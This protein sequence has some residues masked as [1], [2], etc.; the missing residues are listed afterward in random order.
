MTNVLLRHVPAGRVE[1]GAR[2]RL[3][4]VSTSPLE[5]HTSRD[6]DAARRLRFR[7]TNEGD[8]APL[9]AETSNEVDVFRENGELVNMNRPASGRFAH[10]R[11]HGIDISALDRALAQPRV[12]G[13]VHVQPECPMSHARVGWP[14]GQAPGLMLRSWS[15]SV[16]RRSTGSEM[17]SGGRVVGL[18]PGPP[19]RGQPTLGWH[20]IRM[21]SV[22]VRD[23][24]ACGVEVRAR[25]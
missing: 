13:D 9:G 6:V 8:Q 25:E 21:P 7:M 19:A 18:N 15:G 20:S 11:T 2:Q 10:D 4:E 23:V 1:M 17:G 22:L 12:P 14:R 16:I 5:D 24:P 3:D